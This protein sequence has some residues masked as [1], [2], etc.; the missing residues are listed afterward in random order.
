M[1]Y[2]PHTGEVWSPLTRLKTFR[3][4]LLPLLQPLFGTLALLN[5][6]VASDPPLRRGLCRDSVATLSSLTQFRLLK[7]IDK[8]E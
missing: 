6:I 4:E 2:Q 3:S 5:R 7:V 8:S 1:S